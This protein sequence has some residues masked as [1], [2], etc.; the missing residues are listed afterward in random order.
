MTAKLHLLPFHSRDIYL[1]ATFN[2][3]EFFMRWSNIYGVETYSGQFISFHL[4]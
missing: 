1:C 3:S 4:D 2:L